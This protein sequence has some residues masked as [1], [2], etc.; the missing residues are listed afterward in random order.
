M[1]LHTH[2]PR[3][4]ADSNEALSEEDLRIAHELEDQILGAH[5]W[6]KIVSWINGTIFPLIQEVTNQ[7][8]GHKLD[9]ET[10]LDAQYAIQEKLHSA[11]ILLPDGVRFVLK[12][13]PDDPNSLVLE[14]E[15]G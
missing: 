13:S 12:R 1:P 14:L 4:S 7:Y 3:S 15:D 5:V 6:G 10:I 9:D 2:S 8:I 11:G